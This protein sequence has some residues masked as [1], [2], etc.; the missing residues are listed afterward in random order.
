MTATRASPLA[1]CRHPKAMPGQ[2]VLEG[3]DPEPD[4]GRHGDGRRDQ[5]DRLRGREAAGPAVGAGKGEHP[6]GAGHRPHPGGPDEPEPSA[7]QQGQGRRRP[8]AARRSG[9]RIVGPMANR[10]TSPQ[11]GAAAAE[12]G[13]PKISTAC[14]PARRVPTTQGAQSSSGHADGLARPRR[15]MRQP[16]SLACPARAEPRASATAHTSVIGSTAGANDVADGDDG[17]E[18]GDLT[19]GVRPASPC[20]TIWSKGAIPAARARRATM[21]GRAA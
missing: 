8:P 15:V 5:D 19:R 16:L 20:P 14:P 9:E 21:N 1:T 17:A 12:I 2:V 10:I 13:R 18:R 7:Q 6:R 3:G 4:A 11:P